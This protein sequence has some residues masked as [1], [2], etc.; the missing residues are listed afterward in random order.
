MTKNMLLVDDDATFL[1]ILKTGLSHHGIEVDTAINPAEAIQIFEN[2]TYS[3]AVVDLNI[4]GQSGLNLLKELVQI[5]P[6]C[7]ILMLTGYASVATAVEAMRFGA[8]NYLCKPA[9]IEQI[10][11]AFSPSE[12]VET[13][14]LKTPDTKDIA[15]FESMSVKR[16]EW[17]HIQ[18]VLLENDGNVSATAK[19]LNMHRRTLQRKLSKRPVGK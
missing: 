2:K 14:T 15:D 5:Q 8:I 13:E 9:T 19:A 6:D 1:S 12:S 10:L 16:L 4:D 3:H 11:M 17:E 7:K 18:K